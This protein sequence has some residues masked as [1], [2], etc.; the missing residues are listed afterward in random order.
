G[1]LTRYEYDDVGNLLREISPAG[2]AVEFAYLGD[3]GL[4]STFTDG[5]GHAWHYAYGDHER[6]IGITDPLGRR[7]VWQYDNNGNPLSLTGPDASEVRFA[8]NRYGLLT[9]VSDQNGHVQASLFYDHR[10]RLLSATDAEARTQ[11]L[12]YDQQDRLTSWTRPDGATYRLGYRRASW[13]LPEQLIRPDEKEEKRQYDKHNN[14]LN[15]TD[16]NGAVWQQTYGPFDLLTSRTDAEG[17]I[18]QYDYDKDSQQLIGVTAPDGNRWQ[19]WLDADARVIRER[20][21]AGTE[22]HYGYD[23]DGHCISVRN[24]EGEIRHFLYDGRGLLIK[25][26]APDDTL[27]YRY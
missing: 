25:E 27:Y 11:Q 10:Q 18:W 22:T 1:H 6:L 2:R 4:V 14:L 17:R 3:S 7:W 13:R 8:W 5:S 26:T 9:E 24:G 15:Y 12:R 19:W 21:M 20:D 23:E 16:G